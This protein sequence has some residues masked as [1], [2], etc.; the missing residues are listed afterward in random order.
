VYQIDY[1][2]GGLERLI[3]LS[4]RSEFCH[5]FNELY[6]YTENPRAWYRSCAKAISGWYAPLPNHH[7]YTVKILAAG[8]RRAAMPEGYTKFAYTSTLR[9]LCPCGEYSF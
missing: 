1:T 8:T 6:Q 9:T 5:E 2:D 4:P 7:C 3:Q